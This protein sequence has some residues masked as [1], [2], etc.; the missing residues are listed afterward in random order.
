MLDKTL[1]LIGDIEIFI[2]GAGAIVFA[3]SYASF[4]NW[5]KTQAG[6]ALMYFVLS[7]VA[8]F[9][10]NA[11]GRWTGSEYPLREYV[12]FA[13]YT[14]IVITVWRL[15][16]V[17]WRNWRRGTSRP[18]DI[19]TKAR[20]PE[21]VIVTHAVPTPIERLWTQFAPKLIAFLA[22]GLTASGLLWLW[23]Y[24]TGLFGYDWALPP[25]L[26]VII[27]GAVSSVAA[28]IQRDGLLDLRPKEIAS[29]VIVF[30][31]T[32]ISATGILAAASAFGVDLSEYS[33]LI[34]AGVT[35]L[36]ALLGYF[37]RDTYALAA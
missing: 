23:T 13:V 17:L 34:T 16:W 35:V 32:G 6:K 9:I 20:R 14:G 21:G 7:L 30:I 31:L 1:N 36:G 37:K 33:P 5:R 25:E 22:T 28:Y 15:V 2:A 19:E 29:K 24:I 12:R 26:A 18:L 8:L 4:F 27:V 10:L 3:L 11:L